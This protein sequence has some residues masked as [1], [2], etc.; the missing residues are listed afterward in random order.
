MCEDCRPREL[1]ALLGD[2]HVQTILTAT[3]D[4]ASSASELSDTCGASLPTV[5]RRIEEM[6]ACDLLAE[7]NEIDADGNHYK[8]YE[9]ALE[10]ATVRLDGGEFVVDL[11]TADQDDAPERLMRMWTDIREDES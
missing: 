4:Q 2:E 7:R 9:A 10:Q 8:T 6:V 5:Y 11:N 3:S 1:L